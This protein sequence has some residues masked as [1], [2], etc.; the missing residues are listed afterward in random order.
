M[1]SLVALPYSTQ[2]SEEPF[3][4]VTRRRIIRNGKKITE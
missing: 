1:L 3:T 2:S 4:E